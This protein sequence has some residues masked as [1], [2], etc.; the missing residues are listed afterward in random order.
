MMSQN[1]NINV[2]RL[3]EKKIR[4]QVNKNNLSRRDC[5]FLLVS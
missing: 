3:G 1:T 2:L 4:K 5:F